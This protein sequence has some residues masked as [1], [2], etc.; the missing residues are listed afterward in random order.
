MIELNDFEKA[1]FKYI[2]PGFD[3]DSWK[4]SELVREITKNQAAEILAL[5]KKDLMKDAIEGV[6]E[7]GGEFI[8]FGEGIYIDLDPSMQLKPAFNVKSGQKVKLLLITDDE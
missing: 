8:N 7:D 6:V 4:D 1:I 3:E 5:C 2:W